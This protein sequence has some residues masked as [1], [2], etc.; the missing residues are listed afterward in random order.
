MKSLNDQVVINTAKDLISKNGTTTTLEIKNVLRLQGYF[1]TQN[2]VSAIM[3]NNYATNNMDFNPVGDHRE[4]FAVTQN[5]A[6]YDPTLTNSVS[7]DDED[8]DDDTSNDMRSMQEAIDYCIKNGLVDARSPR[9]ISNGTL[10]FTDP[11]VSGEKYSISK[12][13]YV[14]RHYDGNPFYATGMQ[15]YQLNKKVMGPHGSYERVL[16]PGQYLKLAE[17][18]V[19]IAKRHRS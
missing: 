11:Q 9:Q 6:S 8:E 14:R 15:T 7:N 16:L 19:R 10:C 12:I 4:Y 5:A 18:L 17:T 3:F 1:A 2:N 13:G